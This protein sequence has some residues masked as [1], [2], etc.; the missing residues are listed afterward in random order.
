MPGEAFLVIAALNNIAGALNTLKG[1]TTELISLASTFANASRALQDLYFKVDD[2][3]ADLELWKDFWGLTERTSEHYLRTLWGKYGKRVQERLV[4]IQQIFESI[5]RDLEPLRRGFDPVNAAKFVASTSPSIETSLSRANNLLTA[6]RTISANAYYS[7]HKI[8]VSDLLSEEQL[9]KA[10]SSVYVQLAIGTRLPARSLYESCYAASRPAASGGSECIEYIKLELDLSRREQGYRLDTVTEMDT[11]ILHYHFLV[12]W[13]RELA[14]LFVEGPFS[15]D[16]LGQETQEIDEAGG[17][18]SAVMQAISQSR[19]SRVPL[20]FRLEYSSQGSWFKSRTSADEE[21]ILPTNTVQS[22][23]IPIA[24]L[25]YDLDTPGGAE[26]YELF[27]LSQRMSLAFKVAECG[28]LLA[29]TNWLSALNSRLI[30]RSPAASQPGRFVLTTTAPTTDF[31]ADDPK[32]LS[33]HIIQIGILLAEI[34]VGKRIN[35]ASYVPRKEPEFFVNEPEHP[36]GRRRMV[37][38]CLQQQ[39]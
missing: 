6:L 16:A 37:L 17:F 10:R 20:G 21:R 29:G 38:S 15:E 28:L 31:N 2:N 13:K 23:M 1:W 25:L 14:E 32:N 36:L 5:Q 39:L 18:L 30:E 3:Q 22:Q 4:A 8:K 34:G 24:D 27:S 19:S 33:Q 26:N 11:V 9:D 35:I 12:F 7:K